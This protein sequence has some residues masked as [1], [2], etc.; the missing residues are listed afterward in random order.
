[1]DRDMRRLVAAGIAVG[2]LTAVSFGSAVRA[3][4]IKV[5]ADGPL[6][7]IVTQ[8]AE[9]F[10]RETEHKVQLSFAPGPALKGRIAGGE[11]AEIFI[12]PAP[13][14][15]ELTKQ[16]KL[17]ADGQATIA[18]VGLGLAIREGV[19]IPDIGTLEA[20]KETLLRADSIVFNNLASGAQFLKIA[21][22]LGIA[23]DVKTKGTQ[24]SSG[25]A[26]FDEVLKRNGRDIA[27]GSTLQILEYGAKG[28]RLIGQLPADVQ[29][30]T[31]FVASVVAAAKSPEAAREF[32][33]YLQRPESQA[34]FAAAGAS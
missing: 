31:V 6:R 9:S 20:L 8:I 33:R 18:R 19:P 17:S 15:E 29:V 10:Q 13:D 2:F 12:T 23:D 30:H 3:A 24:V 4:D 5:L 7:S 14:T 16:G 11:P 27:V 34:A 21:E 32:I 22:R 25:S 28:L 1:M 26:V